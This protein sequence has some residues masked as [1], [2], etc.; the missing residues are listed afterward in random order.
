MPIFMKYILIVVILCG[1]SIAQEIHPLI[2]QIHATKTSRKVKTSLY[3]TNLLNYIESEKTGIQS[4]RQVYLYKNL[5]KS[6]YE[7]DNQNRIHIRIKCSSGF[8]QILTYLQ[9]EN[10]P[11]TGKLD[12]LQIIDCRATKEQIDKITEID[13]V[14]NISLVERGFTRTGSVNSEGD[15]LHNADIVRQYIGVNGSG[16]RVGVISDGVDNL[17]DAQLTDD[18]P[19]TVTVLDN[20]SGG[21]EGTAMLEIIHDLAPGAEL[22][23]SQGISSS[24][25]FINS[26]NNLVAAGCNVVVD[27]IGYFGEPWFEEGPIATAV[28]NVI[29]N[30]GIVYASSAGNSH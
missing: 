21:D 15:T 4:S 1:I 19:G 22:Y 7:I 3:L 16:I 18:L 14:R 2:P 6:L 27:D 20:T 26:V 13:Q 9:N 5:N 11:I 8:N 28:K 17:A 24:T 12:D 25:A 10:I 23:F 29:Q 30:D